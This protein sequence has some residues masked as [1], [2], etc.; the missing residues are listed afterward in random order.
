MHEKKKFPLNTSFYDTEKQIRLCK[1][2][3]HNKTDW[4]PLEMSELRAW[5]PAPC[6]KQY[7]IPLAHELGV[8]GYDSPK[9]T[10]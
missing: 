7:V 8:Q 3:L 9:V 1:A 6:T 5:L 4:S 10:E 2:H